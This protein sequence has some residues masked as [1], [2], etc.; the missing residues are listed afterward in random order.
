[1]MNRNKVYE[2]KKRN[3]GL[4]KITLWIPE[5]CADDLKLMALICCE[6]NDLIPSTVRSLTTGRMK[7]INNA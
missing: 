7:G 3:N 6:N 5:H 2:Q 1:M 4:K